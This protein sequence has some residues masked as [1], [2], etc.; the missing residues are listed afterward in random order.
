MMSECVFY[1]STSLKCFVY[2]R[3]DTIL[4]ILEETSNASNRP[5]VDTG[6]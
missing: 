2:Y 4:L 1:T 6:Q 5:R 3:L